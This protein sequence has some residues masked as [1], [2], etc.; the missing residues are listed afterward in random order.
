MKMQTAQIYT[1]VNAV[2]KQAFGS[3]A[4]TVSDPAGLISLGKTVLSSST[5][6]ESFLNALVQRIGQTIYAQRLYSNKLRDLNISEMRWGAILQ[7]LSFKMPE[8][9]ADDAYNLVDGQSIDHYVVAKPEVDQKLFVARAPYSFYRTTPMWQLDEAFTSESAM[10]A[11]ISNVNISVRNAIEATLENLGRLTIATGVAEA[12]GTGQAVHLVTEYNAASGRTV[13]AAG[14]LLDPDFLRFAIRRIK[15]VSKGMTDM[16]VL[17]NDGTIERHTPY[18]M[19][20]VRI[21]SDFAL[22]LETEVEYSAF[23]RQFVELEGFTELNYW[24]SATPGEEAQIKVKKLSD[25]TD[26]EINNVVAILHDRDALGIYQQFER[27]LTTPVNARGAY[28]NT[29]YHSMNNRLVD[30]SENLV[31]FALD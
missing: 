31:Y 17:Y 30:Q 27:T 12:T 25:G 15:R 1:L 10:G 18:E 4:I 26:A 7:K 9:V 16:G 6:T 28:F 14:A 3:Q 11:F 2:N 8:A 22:A 21:L 23:N 5:N 13:T 20:R 24:Q 29:F 19:Q